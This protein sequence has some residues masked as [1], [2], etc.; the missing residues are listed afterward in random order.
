MY[1][2]SIADVAFME[3][4]FSRAAEMY[5]EGARDGDE[6]A[7]FNYGYCLWRGLGVSYDPK[8]AKSFFAFAREME[9]GESCYNLAMLY[10]HGEGVTKDF[11][12]AYEYMK[13]S[14]GQ[15]CIEA[16]L[17]LGMAYAS[18]CMLEPEIVGEEH[19]QVAR[20]VQEILVH[21]NVLQD[22]IAI[23]GMDELSVE[24][25]LLVRRARRIQRFL[26]QPFSVAEKFTGTKGIYVPLSET[27]RSFKAILDGEADEY[28]ESAFFNVGTIEDVRRKAELEN[29]NLS[30]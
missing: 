14:A 30:S 27:I 8:E 11:K 20:Q 28:P 24:D 5:L 9:G 16:Q 21:Y 13:I 17:Y 1:E 25:K 4:D 15:G 19:Y 7:S 23:L 18:G 12:T 29:E 26:S 2:K 6:L 22:I 3:G 10:L